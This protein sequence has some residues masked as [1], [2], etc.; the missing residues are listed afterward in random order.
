MRESLLPIRTVRGLLLLIAV[1]AG[2]PGIPCRAQEPSP[3]DQTLVI[4]NKRVNNSRWLAE[5][6][7]KKRGVPAGNL[8]PISCTNSE[9]IKR[10]EFE[11]DILNP[12]LRFME[13]RQLVRF[14]ERPIPV[15]AVDGEEGAT[16]TAS[17]RMAVE[18]RILYAVIMHGVP[19][20]VL[21]EPDWKEPIP[22]PEM[23]EHLR[24]NGASVDAE[25]AL[26]PSPDVPRLGP[27]TNP[28]FRIGAPF[29]PPMNRAM[30][31][32]ARLDGPDMRSIQ[33]MVDDS[34][35]GDQLGLRG[36]AYFDVRGLPERSGHHLG[37]QWILGAHE[38]AV[39]A[40]FDWFRLRSR[41]GAQGPPGDS[42]GCRRG[43]LLRLVHAQCRRGIGSSGFRIPTLGRGVPP[44]FQQRRHPSLVGQ[45][46]GRSADCPGRLRNDGMHGG[47][48]PA[49]DAARGHFPGE[50][51]RRL[52]LGGERVPGDAGALVAD[53]RGRRS[54]VPPVR[55]SDRTA[56]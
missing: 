44:S 52:Q 2:A 46:L 8:C 40:G 10:A 31:L 3:G 12:V 54:V 4:Y 36:R 43:P 32:V 42:T 28:Y 27:Q 38:A 5:Y 55:D 33:R 39:R 50:A 48:L 26:L 11:R 15:P 21:S 29:A 37:D 49:T 6:Y 18:C 9:S 23:P 35:V 41:R 1:A 7:A 20:R 17:I 51:P 47:A 14:E 30:I 25:L 56:D 45:V 34:L 13:R 19:L 53:H 22:P 24:R 16:R